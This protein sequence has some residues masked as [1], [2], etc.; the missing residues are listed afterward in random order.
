MKLS[1]RFIIDIKTDPK[2][3]KNSEFKEVWLCFLGDLG[4]VMVDNGDFSNEIK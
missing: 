3:K 2:N 1:F 4:P